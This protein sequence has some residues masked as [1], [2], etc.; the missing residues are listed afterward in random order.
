METGEPPQVAAWLHSAHRHVQDYLQ[1]GE[2]P[3][4]PDLGQDVIKCVT[5]LHPQLPLSYSFTPLSQLIS[6]QQTPCVSLLGWSTEDYQKWCVNGK[7]HVDSTTTHEKCIPRTRLLLMGYMSDSLSGGKTDHDGNLYVRDSSGCIPC[8][9]P[10]LDLSLLGSLVFFPCWSYLPPK[11]GRGVAEVGYLEILSSPVPIICT[12]EKRVTSDPAPVAAL[13]PRAAL[14]LLNNR[15]RP[16]HT[17]VSIT[18][19]VSRVT[20]LVN[21]RKKC[22][23][24][25]FLQDREACVPVIVQDPSKLSWYHVLC[26]GETYEMTLLSVSSLRGSPHQVFSVTS[27][28]HLFS[29]SLHSPPP[30]VTFPGERSEV[31]SCTSY[32]E[33]REGL[34][35]Q[36]MLKNH[37]EKEAKT[38]TYQ[39]VLTRVLDSRAGLYELDEKVVLCTAYLQL[40]NR[41][42]GMREGAKVEVFDAHLQQSSSP[43]FPPLILSCCLRSRIRVSEFSRLRSHLL[44]GS[45]ASSLHLHLLFRYQL[46]LP[47]YLWVSDIIEKLHGK[48]CPRL[49][50][51]R[52]LAGPLGSGPPG[53]AEKLL[54]QTLSSLCVPGERYE[55]DLQAEVLGEPHDCPLRRYTPLSSP[56]SLPSLSA[57]SSLVSE[58]CYLKSEEINQR[59]HWSLNSL[60]L[61]NLPNP[62]LLVG[63]LHNSSTGDLRLKD[64][65]HSL[66]C[67]ILPR[68]P[69]DWIGCVLEVAQYELITERIWEIEKEESECHRTYVLFHTENVQILHQPATCSSCRHKSSCMPPPCKLPCTGVTWISRLFLLEKVEGRRPSIDSQCG[70]QFQAHATWLGAPELSHAKYE[71]ERE[72]MEE[73]SV[74]GEEDK[75]LRKVILLFSGSSV[76]WFHFLKPNRLY[77]LIATGETDAAIF[78][79]HSETSLQMSNCP[80]CLRV[81]S[82]WTLQDVDSP[83]YSSLPVGV[84]SVEDT[85]KN[86]SSDS[87]LSVTGVVSHRSLCDTQSTCIFPSR[88]KIF[89]DFLPRGVSLKVTLSESSNHTGISAYID[90]SW[91]PYPLGLLPGVTILLQ[92]ME[93]KV[94]RSGSVYLRNVPVSCVTVLSTPTKSSE[95][96]PAPPLVLFHNS[97]APLTLHRAVCSVTCVLNLTLRC[98]CSMCGDIFKK[99][100]CERAPSCFSKSS[101]FKAKAKVKADDGSAEVMVLLQD[102]AVCLMLGVSHHFWEALKGRVCARGEVTAQYRGRNAEVSGD[103]QS[104]DPLLRYVT[105]LVSRSA[106]SRPLLMTFSLRQGTIG[107]LPTEPPQPRRFTKGER[108]YITRV[109]PAPVLTCLHLEEV[110]PRTLSHMIHNRSQS[111][112]K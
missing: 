27:S 22:F 94:S 30:S 25:F 19:E 33:Q 91:G 102:E 47:E 23:F 35:P 36:K 79:R 61:E 44:I 85:L 4:P 84:L 86:G 96:T 10:H 54:S 41:G 51:Q 8:E 97:P 7:G 5:R 108:D 26:V 46:R 16:R 78:D 43:L 69:I 80:L 82:D 18:G 12:P 52:C 40:L 29:K 105:Y 63:V 28:S 48:L 98:V 60:Q 90:V 39:G 88:T 31:K 57:L 89:G 37:R 50:T 106:V 49:V 6:L 70:F 75:K 9:I 20:S 87:L 74:R 103:E 13:P 17:S 14:L 73:E 3:A 59:L 2:E 38:L 101:V 53:V 56:W 66:P 111:D 21:I 15:S 110:E 55:R 100:V 95:N 93:R 32:G 58:S 83:Q 64:Q 68:S 81:P 67:L 71:C 77:R 104:E 109:P 107:P 42:R 76:R 92:G 24:F 34:P 1:E 11:S 65:T 72:I 45:A 99:G 112:V 62:P